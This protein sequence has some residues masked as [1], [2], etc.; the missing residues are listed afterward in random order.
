M[1]L[2]K[3]DTILS[4]LHLIY[5]IIYNILRLLDFVNIFLKRK[6][7][8]TTKV[9]VVYDASSKESGGPSLNPKTADSV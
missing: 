3:L 8:E 6:D 7:R 5:F 2:K 9:R 4:Y 1:S